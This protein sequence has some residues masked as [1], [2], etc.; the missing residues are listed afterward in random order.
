[1]AQQKNRWFLVAQYM[2]QQKNRW[3]LVAQNMAQQN[4]PVGLCA[5]YKDAVKG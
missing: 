4:N 3:F 2:A 1:M 5:L